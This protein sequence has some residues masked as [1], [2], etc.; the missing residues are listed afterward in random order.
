MKIE[1]RITK[2]E[3]IYEEYIYPVTKL[4]CNNNIS[5]VQINERYYN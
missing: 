5:L 3:K 4:R 2:A 1:E